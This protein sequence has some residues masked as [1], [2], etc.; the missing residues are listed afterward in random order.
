MREV[1]L[2]ISAL[3]II[4]LGY[5]YPKKVFAREHDFLDHF[6]VLQK[7]WSEQVPFFN[8]SLRIQGVLDSINPNALG[9]ADLNPTLILGKF[10]D[11]VYAFVLSEVTLRFIGF[12]GFY[13]LIKTVRN[14]RDSKI[15]YLGALLFASL[16]LIPTYEPTVFLAPMFFLLTLKALNNQLSYISYPFVFLIWQWM[17]VVYGGFALL[18]VLI[19]LLFTQFEKRYFNRRK[20][21]GF[22]IWNFIAA[23]FAT[24]RLIIWLIQ[25][26]GKSQRT[27]WQAQ[28]ESSSLI[29]N[30][31]KDFIQ[32]ISFPYLSGINIALIV[33]WILAL[34]IFR[35][36]DS[37]PRDQDLKI[38]LM[39]LSVILLTIIEGRV[40]VLA[41]MGIF[42]QLNRVSVFLPF[43]ILYFLTART[44]DIFVASTRRFGS[45]SFLI[46]LLTVSASFPQ[47]YNLSRN[48]ILEVASKSQT[49][50]TTLAS[51]TKY[52][53]E[54]TDILSAKI[55]AR[56][57]ITI[58]EKYRQDDYN[59]LYSKINSNATMP[60]VLSVGLDPM[61]ASYNGFRSFD[62]YVFNYELSHKWRFRPIIE[63]VLE[64]DSQLKEYFDAWGN[65]V[66]TFAE[67]DNSFLL[68]LCYAKSIGIDY[69]LFP[70]G[71]M[72]DVRIQPLVWSNGLV[73]GRIVCEK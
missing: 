35:N 53:A 50:M 18:I 51:L 43:V 69:I 65:R 45:K 23:L 22:L 8:Y 38:I 17:G 54:E 13:F 70:Q 29:P 48:S 36:R 7:M 19:V 61:V 42:F 68:D 46:L 37:H 60:A 28:Y 24:H 32:A 41:R 71:S 10:I 67:P 2:Y 66:Y 26:K 6:F 58:S 73:A 12:I 39:Y 1:L 21:L 55:R 72:S 30:I 49:S 56:K 33:T 3:S 27:E 5:I 14:F 47:P 9:F 62:G 64:N 15:L 57:S 20:Y 59:F 63:K 4:S 25:S 44:C 31:T 11:P 16:D 52:S 40:E 34:I